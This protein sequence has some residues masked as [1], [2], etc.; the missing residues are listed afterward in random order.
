MTE[1][2]TIAV[3]L[4]YTLQFDESDSGYKN[5]THEEEKILV[6]RRNSLHFNK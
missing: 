5:N 2:F 4:Q 1:L 3:G 6:N